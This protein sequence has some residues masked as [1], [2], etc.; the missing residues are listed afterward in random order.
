[1]LAP[2]MPGLRFT[3]FYGDG[4]EDNERYKR[5]CLILGK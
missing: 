5:V 1:M 3:S 4:L 2:V